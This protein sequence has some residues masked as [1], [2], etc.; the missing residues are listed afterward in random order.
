MYDNG[1]NNKIDRIQKPSTSRQKSA[2]GRRIIVK[3]PLGSSSHL[4]N[5]DFV[6]IF[7]ENVM[8]FYNPSIQYIDYLALIRQP[9]AENEK[10]I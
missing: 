3:T 5:T 6:N 8:Y 1:D 7:V 2:L 10:N 4:N 9:R